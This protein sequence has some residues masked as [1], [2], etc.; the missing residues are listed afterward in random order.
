M[1]ISWNCYIRSKTFKSKY[2]IL[3]YLSSNPSST[4]IK[5]FLNI[6]KNTTT[7]NVNNLYLFKTYCKAILVSRL[8][9]LLGLGLI[10]YVLFEIHWRLDVPLVSLE[11]AFS[12]GCPQ[13]FKVP[14]I[15]LQRIQLSILQLLVEI[16]RSR[17]K[18]R[19]GVSKL[20]SGMATKYE[21]KQPCKL[22][23]TKR[24]KQFARI[25]ASGFA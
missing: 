19:A 8:N 18:A 10:V 12:K 21:L 9:L 2:C 22:G 11:N 14:M 4:L 3:L 16:K 17:T 20:T 23:Y 15:F 1:Q 24:V 25:R 5:D 7:K 6:V 13:A